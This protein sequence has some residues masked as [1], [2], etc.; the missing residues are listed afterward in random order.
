MSQYMMIKKEELHTIIFRPNNF[1]YILS[2]MAK[3]IMQ[4][5]KGPGICLAGMGKVISSSLGMNL[6]F[7]GIPCQLCRKGSLIIV[8]V[9]NCFQVPL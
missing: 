6:I 1:V 5:I 9:P 4:S 7:S 3:S 8:D 2:M